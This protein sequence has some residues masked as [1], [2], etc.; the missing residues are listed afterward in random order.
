MYVFD[1]SF[2]RKVVFWTVDFSNLFFQS[3]K[4]CVIH[5][6]FILPRS[7]GM[8]VFNVNFLS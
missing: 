6:V 5:T 8:V 2:E 3:N 1:I 4:F 7:V